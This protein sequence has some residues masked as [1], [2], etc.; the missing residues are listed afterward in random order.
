MYYTVYAINYVCSVDSEQI[1]QPYCSFHNELEAFTVHPENKNLIK[2]TDIFNVFMRQNYVFDC[3]E[4]LL[5]LT[6]LIDAFV[7]IK[8]IQSNCNK[9]IINSKYRVSVSIHLLLFSTRGCGCKYI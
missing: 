3:T 2:L 6:D 1:G 7:L 9:K 4:F 8:Q 5:L